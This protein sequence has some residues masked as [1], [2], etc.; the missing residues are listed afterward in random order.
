MM[1]T[2]NSKSWIAILIVVVL[3]L[4]ASF[5]LVLWRMKVFDTDTTNVELAPVLALTGALFTSVVAVIGTFLKYSND[6]QAEK[7]LAQ[8]VVVKAIQLLGT[9]TGIDV[10]QTQRAGVLFALANLGQLELAITLL[11][12]MLQ[13]EQHTILDK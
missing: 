12:Q 4:F 9:D 5:F 11:G 10:P 6:V 13:S 3:I 2:K 7:R 1:K 8:E